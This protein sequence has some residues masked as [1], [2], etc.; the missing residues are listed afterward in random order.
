MHGPLALARRRHL[1][2]PPRVAVIEIWYNLLSP[3]PQGRG[4]GGLISARAVRLI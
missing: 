3:A 4:W 1:K 2:R